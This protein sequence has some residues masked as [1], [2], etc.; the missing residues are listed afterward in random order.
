M[1]DAVQITDLLDLLRI[2]IRSIVGCCREG[3]SVGTKAKL[4][5]HTQKW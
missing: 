2:Y 3:Y 5:L 4:K 1:E